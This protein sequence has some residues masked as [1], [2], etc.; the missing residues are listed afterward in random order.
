MDEIV[1]KQRTWAR[2]FVRLV[3]GGRLISGWAVL[4]LKFGVVLRVLVLILSLGKG[5]G[6]PPTDRT[7]LPS[8]YRARARRGFPE[9]TPKPQRKGGHPFGAFEFVDDAPLK[10]HD[11]LLLYLANNPPRN[12]QPRRGR[13]SQKGVKKSFRSICYN[14]LNGKRFRN[15]AI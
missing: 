7:P 12:F 6:Y 3:L 1:S 4:R 9:R 15:F 8:I 10:L 5:Q 11:P 13:C 2:N 14:E